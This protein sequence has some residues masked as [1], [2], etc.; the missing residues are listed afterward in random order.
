M[1]FPTTAASPAPNPSPTAPMAASMA[2]DA[3]PPPPPPPPLPPPRR[4][5]KQLQPRGYQVEVFAAALRGNTIAV[6]NTGSGK[7]M[8]AVMLAREHAR[9]S[10]A[11]E[12][13]RR[14]VVFLAPT[15]HL[16][17]Q[18]F[19]VI[20]EYTDLDAVECHGASGVGEWSAEHWKEEIG[21][22]E[23]VVMTPQILLDA[24]RHAFLTMSAMNLLIFDECHRACGNHPYSR[25]MKEFY[26]GSEW[27]PAVFGMTAS[28]VATKGA[29][30]IEDCEAQIAQ[31]ELILDAKVYFVEGRNELESFAPGATIVNK[32][33][34]AYLIDF[35]DLE[36]KLQILFEEFDALLVSLQESSPNKYED[37][38]SILEMSRKTLSRYHG[39]ILYGLNTLGPIVTLE[40]VKI[41]NE[42][43]KTVGD[44]EDCLFSKASLN[45]QVS[46][47]K[48]ALGLIEEILP[49]G[50]EDIMKSESGSAELTK[51]GY[52]SSKVETLINIFKSFGSSEEVL[53]LIFVER[54]MT[55]K[56]VERFMRGIVNISRFSI[57]Y[58]TGGSTSKDALSPAVQRFTLDLFRSGKVNLLFTTDVTEEG[59]DVPNCSCVIRFDLPRT[60]CSYV[61]SRG[62]AR[63]SSSTYVLMIERGNLVQQEHIFRIIRTEYY[64]KNFALHKQPSTPSYDLPLQ[65]NYTY[66]VDST[67]ATITADCCV[68]LI[69]KYCEKLPKDR[70]YMPKPSFEVGLKD[71]SYQ[72]T[73][74]M[75]PNAAFRSIVGPS[76]STC[77]LAKQLVSLEACK[78]LH[79]LGELSDH[80]VPLIEEPMNIDTTIKDK[81]CLSGPGTTKRKELHGTINVQGLSGNWIHESGTVTLNPYKFD[82]LCDQEGENYAGFVLLMESVLDDDVAHSEIDLFLIPNKIVYTTIT[83]CGKIQLNKEQLHKGKLFQEFFFN[84]IFGRLFHGSRTS[85]L[86]REFLFR[87]G[88][89]IQW[90]SDN[91][92]LLL[93]L[94]HSSHIRH[95]LNINWEAIES[96]SGA[97]EQLRNLYLEDGNLDYGK[98]IP[99]KRN[100]GEDIIHLANK[101]LHFSSVKDSVVLSLHTGRIYSVLDLI[102]DTTA[103]DSFDEMYNGKASPF[104]SFVDY[105]HQKYGIVIQHPGQPLLLLKQSHHAHNLLFSKLKYQDGSTGN[106]LLVGKKQIH[107]R[108]PPELLIHIDVTTDV[109]KSFYLLPSVMHRLQ[110]LMLASQLRRDIGYTQCVPSSLILEAITTLRCCETFSL[111]R[112]ELLG[113]SVL[114][115]VI[116]CDLFLRYPMKHEGHLSDMRSKA[117]CN[118]TLHKHGIWRSLQGYVR[119]S[120]FDTRRWVAPGQISL[121]PF[122]CRCGIE[123]AFVPVDGRYIR[124]D[125]SFV[126]GKPCDRGHR[127]MCSKTV[128]DCVEALVG[129]Y[130]IGGGIAGALWVMRWFGID[131]RC[132][133]QLVQEVKSNAYHLCYLSKLN[134][135]EELEAKLKYSFS[136]KSLL[137]E[138]ITHPSLQELGVDY[139]YQRLEFLG[140]SVLDL[141]ITRHLY[142]THTDIDPGELTD[143]RSALVS[144][145]NF[146][147]AVVRN[148][149]HNHLQHGS[150]ILLEQITEYVKSNLE[151]HGK[152]NEFLQHATCKVPKVLGDIMESI[153]G[154]IFIDTNFNV[155]LVWKI[156]EPLLSP[157]I[158]PDK[159]ALP[160]Y[161]E[162]LELCSHLGCFINSKCTGEGEEL[163]IEMTVQLRDE[164]LIAQGHDRKKKSAKAK[165][166]AH[167]LAD[168]KK[169]GLSIKQ[170]F[171]KAKQLD[172]VSELQFQLTSLEPQ[173]DYPDVNGSHSLEALSS[174]REA[175][176]L[177]LKMDKGGP[178]TALFRLCKS[179]QWPM[180]EFEFVEQRFRTPISLDGVT[181]TNFNSFVSTITLHIPDVTV[182]TLQGERRT[183]KKSSQDSASL[184]MLQKLQELKVCI[185]KT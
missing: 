67:G 129:A 117:V 154:A 185:C 178:R 150:G 147:Q 136:V 13:P 16:V 132:D 54:I 161:R 25:I 72:C 85:G 125:P 8:V 20:R 95:D 90:S 149:I 160:P 143:L 57:S 138:A 118:A 146:A 73:L 60:V 130:Y 21:S 35:D 33:Y 107:A 98:L 151:C 166:A 65:V 122:P 50:Y 101:S 164:L 94:R 69:Y 82:F 48:E 170:C 175:V 183:D 145:D 58:L 11:G 86:Q 156:V 112:L 121:R 64:V 133:M 10:R 123:T 61:Q 14:I 135:I 155:D 59:I 71:G 37:T 31:L 80:L 51:R 140:D 39:K 52:I 47:F 41:Y 70:Y 124:D 111:E 76:S 81:K 162:L 28:P 165:A 9:R 44:S 1:R 167:I 87:K 116:G 142:V 3:D 26:I 163:I 169:R 102:F 77:N 24:L 63:R 100:K 137:L 157:M 110:S 43:I 179:L 158:T 173:I 68:N 104:S 148:N 5:H 115:Y 27:R 17:H 153:T 99:H 23:I 62:R 159:L 91:M 30:T 84:G 152:E 97:V 66:H 176:V 19:E 38:D 7:T 34:D 22:K 79:K 2:E 134:D 109:L 46:Y 131:I 103:D 181:T 108:V 53:C 114:K 184:I 15:V 180:P 75:P 113:D 29:S 144:N 45:L 6:L 32:Y 168:L 96:C 172:I 120:A 106:P 55:A 128:P 105:Y 139:C 177:P 92:Y 40:V 74:T 18:Q 88:Y 126:V 83:P 12:A 119:D 4:P 182:I 93:P 127:W 36:S 49:Q 89:E 78:K 42:S 174:V 56:A 141:L 171:S